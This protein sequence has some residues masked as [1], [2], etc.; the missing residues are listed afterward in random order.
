ME[1]LADLYDN[2]PCGYLS[3]LP[4]PPPEL[5][6]GGGLPVDYRQGAYGAA[7]LL[8]LIGAVVAAIWPANSA[9]RI[10]PV[11]AIGP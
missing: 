1:D 8:T 4:F 3:L 2:A 6:S 11:K 5:T 9:S 10:D 7:I